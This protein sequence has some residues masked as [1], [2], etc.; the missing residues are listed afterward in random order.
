MA[1]SLTI[2]VGSLFGGSS[3]SLTARFSRYPDPFCH[4]R[5]PGLKGNTQVSLARSRER[6]RSR[7]NRCRSMVA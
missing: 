4:R 5:S 7:R 6:G 3:Q 1:H 2:D